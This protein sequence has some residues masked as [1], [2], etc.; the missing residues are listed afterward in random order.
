MIFNSAIFFWFFASF[1][2]LFNF[3]FVDR[4]KI[5]WLLVISSLIFYGTW[6][7]NFIALLVFSALADYL[8][9]QKVE[10][11]N[12]DPVMKK[13]WL[14]ASITLNLSILAIFKY[15]NFIT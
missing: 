13:R 14:I 15:N 10:A 8:I 9:A 12:H 4:R 5:I 2:V 11:N 7:Y 1:F 3:V 6:N